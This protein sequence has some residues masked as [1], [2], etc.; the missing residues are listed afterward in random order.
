MAIENVGPGGVSNSYGVRTASTEALANASSPKNVYNEFG[1]GLAVTASQLP[2]GGVQLQVGG[3]ALSAN[4]AAVI[5]T[6]LTDEAATA[7][8][9]AIQS[10]ID[11]VGPGGKVVIPGGL[12]V[13]ETNSTVYH[14]NII[15]VDAGTTWKLRDGSTCSMLRNKGWNPTRTAATGMTASGR[16]GTISFSGTPPAS[17]LVGKTVS[18]LG[19][20]NSGFN[21]CH[22]ITG[23]GASSLTVRLPRTPSVA[24]ATGA[25]TVSPVDECIGLIGKGAIDYNEENQAADGTMN[26]IA[27]V[28]SNVGECY[29]GEG[30]K[31]LNAKKFCFLVAAY[32][33]ADVDNLHAETS[34]DIIHFLG[35]GTE[36]V[37][38]GVR[39]SS[40]DDSLAFTIGDVSWFNIS[41]GDFYSIRVRDLNTDSLQ[42]LI[43]I[44]GNTGWKFHDVELNNLFG[45]SVASPVTIADFSSELQGL[46][47][48]HIRIDGVNCETATAVPVVAVSSLVTGVIDRLD[49]SVTQLVSNGEALAIN[50][51]TTTVRST[52]LKV[53]N[54]VDGCTKGALL[55]GSGATV[56]SA[57]VEGVRASYASGVFGVWIVG[58]INELRLMD[59]EIG[60]SGSRVVA[61]QGT[62]GRVMMDNIRHSS[63]YR[64]FEQS[65]A[66]N[67]NTE[68]SMS[69]VRANSI[70]HL[71]HF[72][73]AA[74]LVTSNVTIPVSGATAAI[75][76]NGA[77]TAVVW[78]GDARLNGVAESALTGGAT[79]TKSSSVIA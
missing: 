42:A 25:V 26:A 32:R 70:T 75:S 72:E 53:A 41:R 15:E 48:D 65:A 29:I 33:H 40:G 76:A 61:Q 44:S 11:A 74:T 52:R 16:V 10:A 2:G 9:A 5:S 13:F 7:N 20:T 17:L 8:T 24:T 45:S 68:V 64:T 36:T 19:G 43:R 51:A 27:T 55:V 69:N 73:K 6:V 35:P 37:C 79:L 59:V 50:A 46:D 31:F 54:P 63:G 60:G 22:V 62:A 57:A 14:D 66:A 3:S 71:V 12:G 34:S 78:S 4:I 23:R 18:V 28:W 21:G 1:Q 56:N 77:S 58:T 30:L 67:A 49:V 47:C 38:S 39:G